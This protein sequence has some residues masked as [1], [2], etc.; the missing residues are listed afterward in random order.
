MV[1]IVRPADGTNIPSTE[2]TATVGVLATVT[3]DFDIG[4][5]VIW[6]SSVDGSLITANTASLILSAGCQTHILTASVT[7][8][9]KATGSASVTIT[10]GC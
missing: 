1:T 8:S 6:T 2:R 4:L 5:V 7:D 3:D 10:V 9:D